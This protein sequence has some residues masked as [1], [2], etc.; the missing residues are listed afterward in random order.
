MFAARI[1]RIRSFFPDS[2]TN[3]KSN[4]AA[5]QQ[6]IFAQAGRLMP[7]EFERGEKL[8]INRVLLPNHPGH[9]NPERQEVLRQKENFAVEL[10]SGDITTEELS[11]DIEEL[12]GS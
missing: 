5:F 3:P 10:A 2:P 9:S 11:R 4:P 6:I 12:F 1:R 7:P 8:D